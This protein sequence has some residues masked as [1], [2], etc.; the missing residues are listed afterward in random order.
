MKEF[1][2]NDNEQLRN[3][4]KELINTSNYK[5]TEIA[6]KMGISRQNYNNIINVKKKY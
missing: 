1:I 6:E 4:L 2:Y 3:E 5:N